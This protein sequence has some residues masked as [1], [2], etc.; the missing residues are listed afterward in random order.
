MQKRKL[1]DPD[2]SGIHYTVEICEDDPRLLLAQESLSFIS[3]DRDMHKFSDLGDTK[4]YEY[5]LALCNQKDNKKAINAYSNK[6]LQ[7]YGKGIKS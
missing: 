4:R 3:K 5:F 6:H 1:P 2:R 7:R